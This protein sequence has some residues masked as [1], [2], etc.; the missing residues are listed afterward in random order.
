MRHN[1][2]MLSLFINYLK[3]REKGEKIFDL[4]SQMS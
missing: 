2:E 4:L 3:A 1:M